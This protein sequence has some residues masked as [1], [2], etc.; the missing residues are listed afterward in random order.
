MTDVLLSVFKSVLG[1]YS[2]V[3][4]LFLRK[5]SLFFFCA[6]IIIFLFNIFGMLPLAFTFTSSLAIPFFFALVALFVWFT[7]IF[8]SKPFRSLNYFLHQGTN[9]AIAPLIVLIEVISHFS[10]FVSLAVRLFANM[11]AGHLL[12]KAFYSFVFIVFLD[13]LSFLNFFY[14]T[15]LVGFTLFIVT[16][17]F[18]I[19]FL[20]AYVALL[21]I[22]LYTSGVRL[23]STN[24]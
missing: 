14:S 10:K 8:F 9:F 12:L 19:A 3:E 2:T 1:G 4:F 22:V 24:H 20:Q 23:F 21:L 7:L 18:L 15:F 16:L 6:F 17:E 11:F 5:F 13:H